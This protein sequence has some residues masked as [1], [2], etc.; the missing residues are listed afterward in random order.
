MTLLRLLLISCLITAS[1]HA[2]TD[3]IAQAH[4]AVEKL[5]TRSTVTTGDDQN[6]LALS[7]WQKLSE[8]LPHLTYLDAELFQI[9]FADMTLS[10]NWGFGGSGDCFMPLPEVKVTLRTSDVD[11]TNPSTAGLAML[12]LKTKAVSTAQQQE[13]FIK[14]LNEASKNPLC[15]FAFKV[16]LLLKD[17]HHDAKFI[18]EELVRLALRLSYSE[19]PARAK[20]IKSLSRLLSTDLFS[21]VNTYA[22]EAL[23]LI[24]ACWTAI[25][26]PA[27]SPSLTQS[28][29]A[30]SEKET[31]IAFATTLVTGARGFVTSRQAYLQ[32]NPLVVKAE[33]D[34][35][36]TARI[37]AQLTQQ[38]LATAEGK[39]AA[40]SLML[41]IDRMRMRYAAKE[42]PS[43]DPAIT[44][45]A[46]TTLQALRTQAR[47]YQKCNEAVPLDLKAGITELEK[48][49]TTSAK[50]S[51]SQPLSARGTIAQE[52][53]DIYEA[54]AK[55]LSVKL[56]KKST[57]MVADGADHF[58]RLKEAHASLLK[59]KPARAYIAHLEAQALQLRTRGEKMSE[60]ARLRY[61]YKIGVLDSMQDDELAQLGLLEAEAGYLLDACTMSSFFDN[62]LNDAG[63]LRSIKNSFC[64]NDAAYKD[65]RDKLSNELATII[66]RSPHLQ[67]NIACYR[68][69]IALMMPE[70][71]PVFDRLIAIQK[72]VV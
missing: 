15:L 14:L 8:Q 49:L 13:G 42:L 44:S 5:L 2:S 33:Q 22:P 67:E 59:Q 46:L 72:A 4:Q 43:A 63:H 64:T 10:L 32:A 39:K 31:A 54:T 50:S 61:L 9:N 51:S 3:P 23:E 70:L 65:L 52:L 45:D 60:L 11:A 16:G 24:D 12:I 28:T 7:A 68:Y 38:F 1:A 25:I 69:M 48:T 35:N 34:Q 66:K 27:A 17:F 36:R 30:L 57:T 29:A 47:E 18:Q 40:D 19:L 56:S 21:L 71:L 53:A 55:S 58:L 37:N 41:A 20:K 26:N 62:V 6:P